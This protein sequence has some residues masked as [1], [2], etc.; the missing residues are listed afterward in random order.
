[1]GLTLPVEKTVVHGEWAAAGL[2]AGREYQYPSPAYLLPVLSGGRTFP[3]FAAPAAL[4]ATTFAPSQRLSF[5][6]AL[7]VVDSS[8]G[9]A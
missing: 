3:L 9:R 8:D 1:M 6:Y 7:T 2:C 4:V 5:G